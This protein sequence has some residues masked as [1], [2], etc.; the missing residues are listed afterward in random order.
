MKLLILLFSLLLASCHLTPTS[1]YPKSAS[2]CSKCPLCT[3]WD[4]LVPWVFKYLQQDNWK[5]E[6]NNMAAWQPTHTWCAVNAVKI[7]A[8]HALG[9]CTLGTPSFDVLKMMITRANNW[10]YPKYFVSPKR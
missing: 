4:Y 6:I 8:E 7:S 5:A 3:E 1:P 2:E 9:K 10:L